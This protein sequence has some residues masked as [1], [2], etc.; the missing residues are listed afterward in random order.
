MGKA[1]RIG[2]FVLLLAGAVLLSGCFPSLSLPAPSPSNDAP[3][4]SD[5]GT[6]PRNAP[7]TSGDESYSVDADG[8]THFGF[9]AYKEP[10]GWQIYPQQT[11]KEGLGLDEK[12]YYL[13][14][15]QI[16]DPASPPTNISV[17][18]GANRYSPEEHILFRQGILGSL[19]IQTQDGAE[20][21][22]GD[23]TYSAKGYYLYI[24]TITFS[25]N[26]TTQYY[27]VGDKKYFL[28]VATDWHDPEVGDVR[29][30][31][32]SIVDSFVWDDLAPSHQ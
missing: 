12:R 24:F 17:E 6:L 7:I 15:G 11:E 8:V 19:A 22:T 23:G 27:V 10:A 31:A 20:S 25:D 16:V 4:A 9:G 14:E 30:A 13:K 29:E 1:K 2:T 5:N 18:V 32:E 3:T 21:I 26:V 28:V